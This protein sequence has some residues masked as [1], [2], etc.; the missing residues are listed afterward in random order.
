M[1]PRSYRDLEVWQLAMDLTDLVY[2]AS[3]EFAHPHRFELGGQ[4][5]E[6]SVSVPSNIAEGY[7]QRSRKAYIRYLN[8]SAGSLAELETQVEV[9]S[10]RH[11]ARS[12]DSVQMASLC[13]RVG[14]MLNVLITRLSSS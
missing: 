6:A 8:T 4:M 14:R 12:E 1:T 3:L 7:R 2:A 5:R 9:A 10:R 13:D 11:I